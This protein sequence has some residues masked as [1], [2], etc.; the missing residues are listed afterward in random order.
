MYYSNYTN[1]YK[2]FKQTVP[3]KQNVM[4]YEQPFE[5]LV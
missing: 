2:H 1:L 4:Y 3:Y 5:I